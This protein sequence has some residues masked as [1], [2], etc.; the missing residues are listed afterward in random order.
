MAIISDYINTDYDEI[1]GD[2]K[3]KLEDEELEKINQ[4][5]IQARIQMIK[6]QNIKDIEKLALFLNELL[7]NAFYRA[8]TSFTI[9][10]S[11]KTIGIGCLLNEK[12]K[13]ESVMINDKKILIDY[14]RLK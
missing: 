13:I 8:T 14:K 7:E 4:E 11:F 3:N 12:G 6:E 10:E 2:L 5:K 1:E 9:R